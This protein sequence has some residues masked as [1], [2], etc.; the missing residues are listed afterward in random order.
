[1]L[2]L[3]LRGGDADDHLTLKWN[4]HS[5]HDGPLGRRLVSMAQHA[6]AAAPTAYLN[7]PIENFGVL[8]RGKNELSLRLRGTASRDVALSECQLGVFYQP[9]PNAIFEP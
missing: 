1:M 6:H 3:G 8:R 2:R 9:R 7:L 5:L 4:G